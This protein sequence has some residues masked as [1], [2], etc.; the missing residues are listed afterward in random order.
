MKLE[1][2]YPQMKADFEAIAKAFNIDLHELA[3]EA[4][5]SGQ[6]PM[7]SLW[8]M[9][10][11]V[12]RNKETEDGDDFWKWRK[13]KGGIGRTIPFVSRTWLNDEIYASAN[14]DHIKTLLKRVLVSFANP[15]LA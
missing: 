9:F 7:Q 2:L 4:V 6:Y 1:K 12:W 13:N 10:H 15:D 11:E 8:S 5:K 3:N 14:D